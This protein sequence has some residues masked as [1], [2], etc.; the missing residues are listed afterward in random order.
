MDE[1]YSRM[2]MRS[3]SIWDQVSVAL[4]NLSADY[5]HADHPDLKLFVA[6]IIQAGRDRKKTFFNSFMF[7]YL[8][9][10]LELDPEMTF[11]F[12]QKA[13]EHYDSEKIRR[14]KAGK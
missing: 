8:C 11:L 12:I 1:M 2:I 14:L 3:R 13:W 6:I 5:H 9:D 7:N 4:Y 10:L